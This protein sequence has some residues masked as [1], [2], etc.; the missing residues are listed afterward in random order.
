MKPVLAKLALLA[1]AS[2][3][4]VLAAEL[5]VRALPF[6]PVNAMGTV[7]RPDPILDHSL[8][9]GSR[10]RMISAE[11]DVAYAINSLGMRDDEITDNGSSRILLLGDSFMEGYGVARGFILADRLERPGRT[12]LNAG[13]KSYS[14]LLEYLYLR[15]RGLALE[16][17]TVILFFDLSDP[18]NDVYYSRRLITDETGLPLSIRPR[19][20]GGLSLTGP[21]AQFLERHSAL[22]C[23]LRHTALKV[24]PAGREDVGYAGAALDLE[25]LFPGRDSIPDTEYVPRWDHSFHYLAKIR[26]LLQAQGVAFRVVLYPYGH[27][28]S[29]EAW[30]DGRIAH[31]FPPGVSSRRP[32][33]LFLRWAATEKIPVFSLWDTF[34]THPDPGSLYFRNDGHWTAA[35]HAVAAEAVSR[36]LEGSALNPIPATP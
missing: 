25:P 35:G 5:L 21:T 24:L 14:P 34:R 2:L 6:F 23:Y 7:M 8:R 30:T 9:P 32:E 4:A 19:Q 15:H 11:Y 17:D 16:P 12:V 1:V 26:D 29:A 18:A 13:V 31:N 20:A 27:Q 36:W 10:G 28:V 33:E 3:V 22:F